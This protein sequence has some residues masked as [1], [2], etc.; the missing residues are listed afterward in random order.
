MSRNSGLLS[1]NPTSGGM[2]SGNSLA[3]V[4]LQVC[5]GV[6]LQC[7]ECSEYE[8]LLQINLVKGSEKQ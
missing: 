6:R 8:H 7:S 1:T 4:F 5:I 3:A 2:F